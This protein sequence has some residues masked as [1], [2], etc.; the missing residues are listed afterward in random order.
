MTSGSFRSVSRPR[1]RRKSQSARLR[2]LASQS[3][4]ALDRHPATKLAVLHTSGV[5][6]QCGVEHPSARSRLGW[7][8]QLPDEAAAEGRHRDG[9]ARAC[10]QS[11]ARDEHR[12]HEASPGGDPGLSCGLSWRFQ[13]TQNDL[14]ELQECLPTPRSQKKPISAR[15]RLLASQSEAASDRSKTFL[16]NQDPEPT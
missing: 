15:L 6:Q 1:N 2:V 9:S 8:Q 10:L 13:V 5:A 4:V 12:R 14:W 3:E 11:H 7:A 16:R